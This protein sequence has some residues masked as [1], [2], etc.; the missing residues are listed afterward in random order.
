MMIRYLITAF[1]IGS[2]FLGAKF[3]LVTLE[4]DENDKISKI[5]NLVENEL[6]INLNDVEAFIINIEDNIYE[7]KTNDKIYTMEFNDDLTKV[8]KL[9]TN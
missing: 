6:N 5:E 7:V 3:A 1:L 4:K 2:V 8:I 9:V